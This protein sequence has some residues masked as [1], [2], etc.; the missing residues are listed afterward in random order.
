MVEP[1]GK[2]VRQ[3]LDKFIDALK[4]S[5]SSHREIAILIDEEGRVA[6]YEGSFGEV[7]IEFPERTKVMY[8]THPSRKAPL[9]SLADIDAAQVLGAEISCVGTGDGE[10]ACWWVKDLKK[11]E[12]TVARYMEKIK[13]LWDDKLSKV[14]F[15][16]EALGLPQD[17]L[18]KLV[19]S[20]LRYDFEETC[21]LVREHMPKYSWICDEFE[22]VVDK[23]NRLLK[24]WSC[25][26]WRV[27]V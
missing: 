6:E 25:A 24:S 4:R 26:E 19:K 18:D 10:V 21:R 27:K 15:G 11:I 17:V 5:V 20:Y 8:H 1:C 22:K 16:T 2:I 3:Y 23:L 9:H 12:S 14:V 13:E 7:E